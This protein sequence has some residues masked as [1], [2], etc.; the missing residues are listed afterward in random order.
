MSNSPSR[1]RLRTVFATIQ[2]TESQTQEQKSI[3]LQLD[4][5]TDRFELG[6][7]FVLEFGKK[8][9]FDSLTHEVLLPD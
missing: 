9:F 7:I 5:A 8:V 4:D 6:M 2:H 1:L 3:T